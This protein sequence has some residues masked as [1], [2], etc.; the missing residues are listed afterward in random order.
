M[1][2]H[3]PEFNANCGGG[4]GRVVLDLQASPDKWM[5]MIIMM[6]NGSIEET[7]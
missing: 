5:I 4:G 2:Y 6:M 3:K 7:R 1:F